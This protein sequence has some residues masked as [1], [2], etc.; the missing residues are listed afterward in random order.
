MA[1]PK[2]PGAYSE[3]FAFRLDK[4]T[5]DELSHYTNAYNFEILEPIR[6]YLREVLL[7]A[8]KKEALIQ[9]GHESS[10]DEDNDEPIELVR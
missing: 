8:L 6:K 9:D 5:F 10:S 1:R 3:L 4:R 7:P 2:K